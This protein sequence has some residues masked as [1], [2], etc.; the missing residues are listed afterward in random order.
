[1]KKKKK[2][3]KKILILFKLL[4]YKVFVHWKLQLLN[5]LMDSVLIHYGRHIDKKV[6]WKIK[7]ASM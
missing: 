1:M 6:Y 5:F 2:K 4:W 3:K 7:T